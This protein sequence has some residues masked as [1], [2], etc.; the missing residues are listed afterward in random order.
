MFQRLENNIPVQPSA[1]ELAE[2]AKKEYVQLV[3]GL[4]DPLKFAP[5]AWVTEAEGMASWPNV[6]YND[7]CDHVMKEHPGKKQ[8][9]TKRLLNDYKEGKAFTYYI[10]GWLQ[11]IYSCKQGGYIFLLAKCRPSQRINDIH[12]KTWVCCHPTGTVRTAYCSCTAGLGQSCNHVAALLFKVEAAVRTN[13]VN[14]ACTSIASVWNTAS[15]K[16]I[17]SS[18]TQDMEF[19]KTKFCKT[20]DLCQVLSSERQP[21]QHLRFPTGGSSAEET[22]PACREQAPTV[23]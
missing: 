6:M 21:M 1:A 17:K 18:R 3:E 10:D 9:V 15:G 14:P 5:D 23:R 19:T 11:E 13:L 22:V 7:I 2:T 16:S 20:V 4:P 12:H 8:D